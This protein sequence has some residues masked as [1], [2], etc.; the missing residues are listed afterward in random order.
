MSSVWI[1]IKHSKLPQFV[2]DGPPRYLHFPAGL[3][4]HQSGPPPP[5]CPTTALFGATTSTGRPARASATGGRCS[6]GPG[7][8][9]TTMRHKSTATTPTISSSR[10][11]GSSTSSPPRRTASGARAVCTSQIQGAVA[12]ILGSGT[13]HQGGREVAQVW[14]VVWDRRRNG[15]AWV[16][17]ESQVCRSL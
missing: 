12:C 10:A 16:G 8:T 15:G 17:C 11:A 9:T 1:I 13:G 6:G 14:R 7:S 2:K 4:R 5:R 3:R